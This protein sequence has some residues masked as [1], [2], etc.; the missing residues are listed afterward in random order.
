MTRFLNPRHNIVGIFLSRH[1]IVGIFLLPCMTGQGQT[2]LYYN[3]TILFLNNVW[4]IHPLGAKQNSFV[5]LLVFR[6]SLRKLRSSLHPVF[7]LLGAGSCRPLQ[8]WWTSRITI[9]LNYGGFY[10]EI[11]NG[12]TGFHYYICNT[13]DK[14]L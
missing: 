1:N 7:I 9:S 5:L 8:G 11:Y 10:Y 3:H 13:M 14:I 2:L 12:S 4:P 6:S